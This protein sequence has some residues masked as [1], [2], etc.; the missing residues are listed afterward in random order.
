MSW[1]IHGREKES[2]SVL[3]RF[4][5]HDVPRGVGAGG[6]AHVVVERSLRRTHGQKNPQPHSGSALRDYDT[7]PSR[8]RTCR[9]SICA[10]TGGDALLYPCPP[11]STVPD[12]TESPAT[13]WNDFYTRL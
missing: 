5:A 1:K 11:V 7:G 2:P 6:F 8:W 4:E 9:E 3:E 13:L 10:L 12:S